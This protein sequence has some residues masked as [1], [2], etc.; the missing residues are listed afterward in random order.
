MN[1]IDLCLVPMFQPVF[2]FQMCAIDDKVKHASGFYPLSLSNTQV[3]PLG[4]EVKSNGNEKDREAERKD[5][6]HFESTREK[7]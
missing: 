4:F 6:K 5:K 3:L 7:K 2:L 1:K